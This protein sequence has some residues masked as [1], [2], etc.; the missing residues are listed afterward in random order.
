MSEPAGHTGGAVLVAA[1]ADHGVDT[2]FGIPGT[3]NLSVYAALHRHGIRH[4]LPRHEQGAGFAA[5]GYARVSRRPGVCLTTTGPAALNAATALAQAYSD[6]VPVLAVSP[7]MP[8][9]HPAFGNG[10]LHE[11]KDQH[12]ALDAVCAFSHRVENVQEIPAAVAHAFAAMTAERPRSV[13]LEIP[14]DLLDAEAGVECPAVAPIAAGPRPPDPASS[15]AAAELLGRA[16]RP[17]LVVGGGAR[18]A[19]AEVRELAEACAAPVIMSA[20]GKGVVPADH[21]LVVGSGMHLTTVTELVNDSDVVVAVGTELAPSDFW[22]EPFPVDATVIR[23][24]IDRTGVAANATPAVAVVGDAATAVRH[25][26]ESLS[27]VHGQDGHLRAARWREEF[28]REAVAASENWLGL[29][30]GMTASLGRNF[31]VAG[32]SATV[33]YMGALANL[34]SYLPASFLYPSGLGTLG[35]GLPAAIGAKIARPEDRVMALLG[36]GGAMFTIA[37][38]ATAAQL[39]LPLP[40]VIVDNGGYGEI[41]KEMA[42]RGEPVHAVQLDRVDFPAMARAMGCYGVAVESSSQLESE[43][44][45]AFDADRP[46][47]MHIVEGVPT[48]R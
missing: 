18:G 9:G 36:D 38:L 27:P 34:P 2:V 40:V 25:L 28:T 41:G 8:L 14:L 44:S 42:E 35:Y 46:T 4:V 19:S 20:N 6:S 32:D 10:Y 13:H 29:L 12:R 21:P 22:L 3:H 48:R 1:L 39:G 23:I 11:V 26:V 30:D 24:D 37:E 7:G 43:L 33:C 16:R 45:K 47:V 5:D 15:A 31:V 17:L